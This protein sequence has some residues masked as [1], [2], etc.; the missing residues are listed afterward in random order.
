MVPIG[1][2]RNIQRRLEKR[3][4]EKPPS[5]VIPDSAKPK[6][7][8]LGVKTVMVGTE[9]LKFKEPIVID[10]PAISS[11]GVVG[12]PQGPDTVRIVLSLL[13]GY[14]KWKVRCSVAANF[15]R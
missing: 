15:P 12:V 10:D 9:M 11:D 1:Q 3:L 14:P 8:G 7:D 5:V 4:C 6:E 2:Y 13:V